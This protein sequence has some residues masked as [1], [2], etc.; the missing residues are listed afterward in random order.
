MVGPKIWR[1][2]EFLARA[3]NRT[4]IPPS[5]SPYHSHYAHYAILDSSK[6]FE[7]LSINYQEVEKFLPVA[8]NRWLITRT[9]FKV[10]IHTES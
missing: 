4:A 10:S 8:F 6:K 2:E 7:V 1:L 9:W 3:G 5:P